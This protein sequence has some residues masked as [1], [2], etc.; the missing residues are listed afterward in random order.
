MCLVRNRRGPLCE[1]CMGVQNPVCEP[2][3]T[4]DLGPPYQ[5]LPGVVGLGPVCVRDAEQRSYKASSILLGNYSW[6]VPCNQG[7]RGAE[8]DKI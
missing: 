7:N 1:L 8:A 5:L 2:A 6:S 3:T 4:G